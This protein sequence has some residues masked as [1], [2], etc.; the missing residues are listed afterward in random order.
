M[1]NKTLMIVAVGLLFFARPGS[2]TT[3]D[4]LQQIGTGS[5]RYLGV[6]KVYDAA[7]FAAEDASFEDIQEARQSHCL[8][9][10]YAVALSADKFVLAADKILKR[11]HDNGIPPDQVRSI[12]KLHDA[13]RSVEKGDR[14]AL[15]FDS[16]SQMTGLSLNG[17]ELVRIPSRAFA[18]LYMGIWLSE[19]DPID[20]TLQRKLFEPI[21]NR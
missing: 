13:Y 6:I 10:D 14:Y 17:E 21:R 7:L 3:V 20:T 5:I 18:K 8:V 11:Q 9:L 16:D 4:D 12:D 15:C 2:A 1:M 19:K